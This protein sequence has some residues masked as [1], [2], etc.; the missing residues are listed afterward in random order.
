MGDA[1]EQKRAMRVEPIRGK[2]VSLDFDA[3]A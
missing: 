2:Q 1:L 3:P